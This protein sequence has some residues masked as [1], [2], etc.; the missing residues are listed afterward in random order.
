MVGP[1]PDHNMSPDRLRE[2][3]RVPHELEDMRR[4]HEYNRLPLQEK[5]TLV[6]TALGCLVAEMLFLAASIFVETSSLAERV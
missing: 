2:T 4:A 3:P 6:A 1:D 5:A